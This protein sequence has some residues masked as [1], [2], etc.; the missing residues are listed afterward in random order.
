M[1]APCRLDTSGLRTYSSVMFRKFVAALFVAL[2]FVLLGIEFSE[3]MG[4]IQYD[5]PELARCVEATLAS[6]GEAIK[7]SDDL[8]EAV[9]SPVFANAV[10][11]FRVL[12]SQEV[13]SALLRETSEFVKPDIPIYRLRQAFLI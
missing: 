12:N 9:P 1:P 8:Q 10:A 4:F 6:F 2:W 7:I 3:D 13:S 5:E 11:H